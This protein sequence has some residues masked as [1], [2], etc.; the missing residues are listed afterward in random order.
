MS[1]APPRIAALHDRAVLAVAGRDARAFLHAQL[2]QS[3]ADLPADRSTLAAWADARGRVRALL[4]VVQTPESWLLVTSADLADSVLAKLRLYVLRAD[5]ALAR[6]PVD[7][8]ALAGDARAWLASAGIELAHAKDAQAAAHGVTW[9]RAGPELVYAL[10]PEDAVRAATAAATAAADGADAVELAEIRL[11]LPVVD[12]SST[13]RY[14]PQMLNLD[15]LGAVSFGKGCYP[16]QEVIA[17]TQNLGAV[18]RRLRA[19]AAA[20]QALPA[21]GAPITGPDGASAGEVN[22]AARAPG[23]VELLAVVRVDLPA[24]ALSL[25][26]APLTELAPPPAPL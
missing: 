1:N 11:G 3:I 26:G 9:V 10:G 16:G 20:A 18:K 24:A 22:R 17:R 8:F 7:V 25:D 14:I 13:E 12:T 21:R 4:R 6:A 23:G 5:V 19:F 2:T 15:E